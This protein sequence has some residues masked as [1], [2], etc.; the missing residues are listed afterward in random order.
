MKRHLFLLLILV[1]SVSRVFAETE[2]ITLNELIDTVK[3]RNPKILAEH[4][5]WQSKRYMIIPL[6]TL[7]DLNIMLMEENIPPG[8]YSP[9]R[10]K[11]TVWAISQKFPFFGKLSL[12][13]KIASDESEV[14][15]Y[16]YVATEWKI[17]N[18]LEKAY[19][20]YFFYH[21]SVEIFE[22]MAEILRHYSRVAEQ[23]YLT[24]RG[25]QLNVLKSQVEQAKIL[26][27]IIILG[28]KMRTVQAEIN[29]LLDYPPDRPLGI[30]LIT[31]DEKFYLPRD[32]IDNIALENNPSLKS[33]RMKI[34]RAEKSLSLSRMG[35]LP[36]F[37]VAYKRRHIN[38]NYSGWD[39]TLSL[40]IPL[41][42]WKQKYEIKA[43]GK[44]SESASDSYHD[45][46]NQILY[47][48]ESILARMDTNYRSFQLYKTNF[49]PQAEQ[50]RKV[51]GIGYKAQKTSF[52]DVLDTERSYLSFQ[53]DKW[54]HFIEYKKNVA[55]LEEI[56]GKQETR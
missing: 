15:K 50:A 47:R 20:N 26:N 23:M 4:K 28:E 33:A 10:S 54:K 45:L 9:R 56:I 38:D 40:N 42:F 43:F 30:P 51:A 17:I 39:A 44:L 12:R 27:E 37:H 1:L 31:L 16:R 3:K 52:L 53:V 6:R 36:D 19:F 21:K 34:N 22:E 46:K 48:I 13:G 29:A 14:Y 41:Y 11:M 24:G 2:E 32:K 18:Q 35:Y 55:D 25:S 49:L 8:E 5:I 7:P